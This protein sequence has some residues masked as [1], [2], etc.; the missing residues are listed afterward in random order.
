MKTHKEYDMDILS[1][2]KKR[3]AEALLICSDPEIN[4]VVCLTDE[5]HESLKRNLDCG[6]IPTSISKIGCLNLFLIWQ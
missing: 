1:K 5:D 3:V 2:I 6:T 4:L